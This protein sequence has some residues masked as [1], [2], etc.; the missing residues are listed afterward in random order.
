MSYRPAPL[1]FL[2]LFA[3]TNCGDNLTQP[4]DR[5][6]AADPDPQPLECVPNLDAQ[7]DRSELKPAIGT[8]VRY[9]ISP[10]GQDRAVDLAGTPNA[11]GELVWD[12]TTDYADDQALTVTPASLEGKWYASSFPD[13][14][15]VTPF[16]REGGL[17]TIGFVADSGFQLL[18][19]AS[20]EEDPAEGRTLLVYD[21]P[22]TLLQFPAEVGQSFVSSGEIVNGLVRGLPY[23]GRDTYEV[24]IDAIGQID[25]PQL[26]F[27]EVLRVRTKVT[28]EPAV[29]A[30]AVRYQTSFFSECF[31]EVAR[32]T[33]KDGE[34]SPDFTEAAELRRLGY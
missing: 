15:F 5:D 28:V 18:G 26:T 21:P 17:E 14:A 34:S 1:A 31:A 9:V 19:I 22:I 6:P 12:F 11:D 27:E 16:D 29:G 20:R 23:A 30:V 24:N 13:G 7:I 3:L 33:S 2:A 8:P 25:L 32:A 4:P 10:S